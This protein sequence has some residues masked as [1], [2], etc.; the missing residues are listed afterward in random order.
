[1]RFVGVAIVAGAVGLAGCGGS[2]TASGPPVVTGQVLGD[3]LAVAAKR[4]LENRGVFSVSVG[5]QGG[6]CRG[7]DVLWKCTLEIVPTSTG[8][9]RDR[10]TYEMRVNTKGCWVARQT[11]TD[12]GETGEP[13]RPTHP[14]TL[15]G[16]LDQ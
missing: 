10:R 4:D 16:C 11:G 13:R 14:Q 15:K 1:V 9:V 12:V 2:D 7:R 8:T 3:G 5:E 6:T